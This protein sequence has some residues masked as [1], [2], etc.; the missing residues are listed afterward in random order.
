[1][2]RAEAIIEA[3]RKYQAGEFNRKVVKR[4]PKNLLTDIAELECGHTESSTALNFSADK[5]PA[6]LKCVDR[7]IEE[8]SS[9]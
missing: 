8:N 4:T 7:W 2:T 5:S 1:M 3:R 9:D 6:C